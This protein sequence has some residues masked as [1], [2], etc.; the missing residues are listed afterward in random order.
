M[1]QMPLSPSRIGCAP[2]R[3]PGGLPHRI[4]FLPGC[5][6]LA[7]GDRG[8]DDGRS[9]DIYNRERHGQSR[10]DNGQSSRGDYGTR[11]AE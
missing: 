9:G 3:I 8:V 4:C 11:T 7:S 2:T 10:T 1:H 6:V 5:D